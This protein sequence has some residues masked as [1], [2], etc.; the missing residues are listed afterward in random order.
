[1]TKWH[2]GRS[3]NR[4]YVQGVAGWLLRLTLVALAAS[5]FSSQVLFNE[6]AAG[7][8]HCTGLHLIRLK[9]VYKGVGALGT[10]LMKALKCATLGVS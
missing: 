3:I 8:P 4:S 1:V 5:D 10:I 6:L 7:S 9:A 2:P